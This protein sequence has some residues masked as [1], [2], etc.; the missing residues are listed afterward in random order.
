[1]KLPV[2]PDDE[3]EYNRDMFKKKLE[4]MDEAKRKIFEEE[5]KMKEKEKLKE[6]QTHR[7]KVMRL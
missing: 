1:M 5:Q 2:E 7:E 3:W 6:I 4:K